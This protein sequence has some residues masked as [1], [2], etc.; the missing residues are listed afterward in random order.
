MRREVAYRSYR[1]IAATITGR[2]QAVVNAGKT[3]ISPGRFDGTTLDAAIAAAA[4]WIDHRIAE[5]S[6]GQ[7]RDHVATTAR[8]RDFL[9]GHSF[10]PF[11]RA[12]LI[13][14]AEHRILT[15]GQLAEA[16]GWRNYHP[17]NKNYGTL[18]AAAA[19]FLDL[20]PLTRRNG[21]EIWTTTLAEGADPSIADESQFYQ[22]VIHRE[23]ADAVVAEGL[24]ERPAWLVA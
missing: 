1:I 11:E 20:K 3:Q 4:T 21:S 16:G 6:A 8:Y 14:H 9:K 12:M 15:A 19:A 18:G 22:W 10:R 7:C 2:P 13:A 17:A 24:I 23:L 5:Q